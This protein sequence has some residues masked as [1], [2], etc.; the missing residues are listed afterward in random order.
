MDNPWQLCQT[1][2]PMTLHSQEMYGISFFFFFFFEN[3]LHYFNCIN[4]Q[5]DLVLRHMTGHESSNLDQLVAVVY[6]LLLIIPR[7][8]VEYDIY[9]SKTTHKAEGRV[10]CELDKMY[11]CHI[12]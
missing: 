4:L 10:G 3:L 1:M 7:G 2:G 9:T 5:E 11:I 8:G 6:E 12:P